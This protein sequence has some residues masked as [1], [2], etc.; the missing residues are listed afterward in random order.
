MPFRPMLKSF[1]KLTLNLCQFFS[2]YMLINYIRVTSLQLVGYQ[3][4][5]G[6]VSSFNYILISNLFQFL[7]NLQPHSISPGSVIFL[8]FLKNGSK[9]DLKNHDCTSYNFFF[10][11]M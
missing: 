9:M 6:H 3:F 10:F 7:I 11:L 2:G 8:W 5:S 1:D 4:D